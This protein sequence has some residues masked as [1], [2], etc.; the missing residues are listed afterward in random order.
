MELVCN[1]LT[2]RTPPINLYYQD[3]KGDELLL[4]NRRATWANVVT[5]G[6]D[7]IVLIYISDKTPDGKY[8][9]KYTLYSTHHSYDR[10]KHEEMV[11]GLPKKLSPTNINALVSNT[12]LFNKLEIINDSVLTPTPVFAGHGSE[13]GRGGGGGGGGGKPPEYDNWSS[14]GKM[15]YDMGHGGKKKRKTKRHRKNRRNSKRRK[16]H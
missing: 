2:E 13:V 14:Y 5:I 11:S 3:T 10:T 16:H 9:G 8:T 6:A 12:V 15:R 1:L 7:T 4:S